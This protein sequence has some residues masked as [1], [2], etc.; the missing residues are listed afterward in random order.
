MTCIIS[1]WLGCCPSRAQ[2]VWAAGGALPIRLLPPSLCLIL[3]SKLLPPSLC[4][5]QS[6]NLETRESYTLDVASPAI[7]IQVSSRALDSGETV[8]WSGVAT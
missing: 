6:L 7:V 1:R 4:L 2:L 3:P 8:E 5:I